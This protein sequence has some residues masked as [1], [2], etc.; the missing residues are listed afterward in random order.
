MDVHLISGRYLIN[1]W[2]LKHADSTYQCVAN[3]HVSSTGGLVRADIVRYRLIAISLL[4]SSDIMLNF[5]RNY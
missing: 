4:L 5:L 3:Y 1:G 2:A